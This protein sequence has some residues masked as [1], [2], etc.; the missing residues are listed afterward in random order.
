MESSW[1]QDLIIRLAQWMPAELARIAIAFGVVVV[2]YFFA[3]GVRYLVT[4]LF[5]SVSS[6][7]V[8]LLRGGGPRPGLPL[9]TEGITRAQATGS[10][11]SGRVAFW[12]V[13]TLFLGAGTTVLGFPVL[14]SWMESLAAYLPRVLASI[15]ILLLGVLSG[16][17]IRVVVMAAT[18]ASGVARARALG[19]SAQIAVVALAAVM[20]IEGLGIEV[21]FPLVVA[22]VVLGTSLGGAALAFGLG[23]RQSVGNLIA[24]HDLAKWYRVG[25]VVQIAEHQG[26][27]SEILPA[28]VVLQTP[29]GKLY[30]PAHYFAEEPSLLVDEDS[31]ED[32]P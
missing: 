9:P 13:F 21:T 31:P 28:A 5:H 30:V 7:F 6:R 3:R 2:G 19:R 10:E 23:A 20:A 12:L 27:I 11:V 25:Q 22:A 26:R 18:E 24:C 32:S 4:R 29:A 15:A 17:F 16:L 1:V 14:T 8:S